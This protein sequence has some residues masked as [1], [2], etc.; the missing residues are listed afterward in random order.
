MIQTLAT[1]DIRTLQT[2]N[3]VLGQNPLENPPR[4]FK[5]IRGFF[6]GENA[7]KRPLRSKGSFPE[8][9]LTVHTVFTVRTGNEV[10]GRLI[11]NLV[12]VMIIILFQS[13]SEDY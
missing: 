12:L 7:L 2:V 1:K 3:N 8:T 13:I 6:P 11:I 9:S 10:L 4:G 5:A